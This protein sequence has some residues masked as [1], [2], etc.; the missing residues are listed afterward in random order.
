MSIIDDMKNLSELQ[1]RL[2]TRFTNRLL[3][4]LPA[5]HTIIMTRKPGLKTALIPTDYELIIFM[6][7][8]GEG[9]NGEGDNGEGD[10][11]D[12][13]KNRKSKSSVSKIYTAAGVTYPVCNPQLNYIQCSRLVSEEDLKAL[14]YRFPDTYERTRNAFLECLTNHLMFFVK[15]D[16]MNITTVN[17]TEM[18]KANLLY[19]QIYMIFHSKTGYVLYNRDVQPIVTLHTRV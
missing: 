5:A 2:I 13:S 19:Y 16:T 15:E 12:L 14:S 4:R 17:T 18:K 8:D 9:D 1:C 7:D 3:K 10:D 6:R 11:N